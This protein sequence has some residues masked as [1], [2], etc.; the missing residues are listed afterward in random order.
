MAKNGRKNSKGELL[1][2][3]VAGGSSIRHAAKTL[4]ITERTAYRY[5]SCPGFARRVHE[6]RTEAV[7]LAMGRLAAVAVAAVQA[8]EGCLSSDDD[9]ARIRAATVILDRFA[10]LSDAVDIRERLAR[11]E[12]QQGGKE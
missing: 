3:M 12:S 11:L 4:G 10:K 9:G 1:A 6:I 5:S 8:L 7:I 2:A